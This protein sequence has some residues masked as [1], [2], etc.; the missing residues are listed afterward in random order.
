MTNATKKKPSNRNPSINKPTCL[1]L[2]I[3][4]LPEK[5]RTNHAIKSYTYTCLTRKRA[6][7]IRKRALYIC[8]RVLCIRQRPLQILKRA[9]Y[10]CKRALHILKRALYTCKRA[11]HIQTRALYICKRSLYYFHVKRFHSLEI[12]ILL[13]PTLLH[14]H[15]LTHSNNIVCAHT[16]VWNSVCVCLCVFVCICAAFAHI[17]TDIDTDTG[18]DTDTY[19]D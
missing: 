2:K 19:T 14:T 10:I 11:L 9:L 13:P 7:Y 16:R 1:E 8:Q 3:H 6:L 17:D 5:N 4:Q 18:T 15:T 12:E